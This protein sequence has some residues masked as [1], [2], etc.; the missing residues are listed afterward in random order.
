MALAK[1]DPLSG[2]GLLFQAG[3]PAP[4]LVRS[5][6]GIELLGT[7]GMPIGMF[8]GVT[9]ESIPFVLEHGDTLVLYSDGISEAELPDGSLLGE[10]GLIAIL[11]QLRTCPLE[12]YGEEL[13]RHLSKVTQRNEFNDDVSVLA[14]R[15]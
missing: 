6:G 15:L 12:T 1:I 8:A 7:G 2:N 3:H 9:Y 4:A 14:L 13:I 5:K 11:E 10:D